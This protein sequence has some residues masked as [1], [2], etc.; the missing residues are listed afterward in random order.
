M[1]NISN[2]FFIN[3]TAAPTAAKAYANNNDIGFS[4]MM[5]A[6]NTGVDGVI[7]SLR[8]DVSPA[9]TMALGG[10][11]GAYG[12]NVPPKLRIFSTK[13]GFK[14]EEGDERGTKFEQLLGD[15]IGVS[16]LLSQAQT[17]ALASRDAAMHSAIETFMQGNAS[18]YD[19]NGFLTE[20]KEEQK[21][22]AISI[23]YD[24]NSTQVEE[25]DGKNWRPIKNE[26][27]FMS[28][29][30]KAYTRYTLTQT[31]TEAHQAKTGKTKA[32][33]LAAISLDK[34]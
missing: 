3:N 17:Q 4:Q 1:Q 12:I 19:M 29:L 18:G 2:Q 26:S 11:V 8:P 23:V 24:G 16:D 20:F 15:H 31:A 7:S 30:I 33:S 25:L 6:R 34:G 21:P 14:L 13:K 22:R 10:L 5:A 27:D 32:N 28:D 9:L